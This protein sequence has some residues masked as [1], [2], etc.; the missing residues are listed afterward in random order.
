M[1]SPRTEM[2]RKLL[3]RDYYPPWSSTP[4]AN[5]LFKE[6]H[7]TP[8]P[9][10]HPKTRR[11]AQAGLLRGLQGSRRAHFE[12]GEDAEARDVF[13]RGPPRRRG[14]RRPADLKEIDVFRSALEKRG[15]GECSS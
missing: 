8:R 1:E 5:E 9:G 14:K 3:Q 12:L 7:T 15:A 13:E 10:A 11:R 4:W 2:F 6:A